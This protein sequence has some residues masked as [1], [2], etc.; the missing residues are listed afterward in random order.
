MNDQLYD[1][2]QS[3]LDQGGADRLLA[4]LAA[5]L[6][7]EGRYHELFDLRLL[8]ARRREGLPL[9]ASRSLDDLEEPLRSKMENAYLTACREIG[10]LLLAEGRVRDAWLYLRP[11]GDKSGIRAALEGMSDEDQYEEIIELAI[12]EGIA[13]RLGFEQVLKHYGLCNAITMFEGQLAERS[14]TDRAEVARLLVKHLHEELTASLV[15]DIERQQGTRP[16]PASIAELVK[17]RDW[18]FVNENYHVDTTHLAAIVRFAMMVDDR[19]TLELALDLCSYGR[20]LSPTFQ[21]PGEEP[22]VDLYPTAAMYFGALLGRDV[23]TA[24]AWFKQ[25]ADDR[26]VDQYGNAPAEVYISLL[27]RL[28]RQEEALREAARLLPAGS[29]GGQFGPNLFELAEQ[30][31]NYATLAEISRQRDDLMGFV[32]G[33]V[34]G[35]QQAAP[36]PA[37]QG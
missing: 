32:V 18:L 28:G 30:G 16:K 6:R 1:E 11:V 36:A 35:T 9:V 17:D 24:V 20:H 34:G 15:A 37:A 10:G 22:F 3:T 7:T 29:R 31:Q 33:L 8:E 13:P 14:R 4:M 21:F 12:Y 23:D 5:R 25:R 27:A 19:Q 26:P 2:L